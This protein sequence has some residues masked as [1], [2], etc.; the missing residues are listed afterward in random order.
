M[1]NNSLNETKFCG[2][3]SKQICD[4]FKILKLAKCN[5]WFKIVHN[6]QKDCLGVDIF[7]CRRG[8]K[9][10]K[11]A[12]QVGVFYGSQ[13]TYTKCTFMGVENV[14]IMDQESAHKWLTKRYG[15]SWKSN[16]KY[17]K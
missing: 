1:W 13:Q 3:Q 14:S 12:G 11:I 10:A 4:K 2:W 9:R 6:N 7:K 16:V 8:L 17:W 15:S 5:N